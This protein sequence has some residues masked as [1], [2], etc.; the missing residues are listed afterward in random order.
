MG[1]LLFSIL[2]FVAISSLETTRVVVAGSRPT[3]RRDECAKDAG[4]A[5]ALCG[6]ICYTPELFQCVDGNLQQGP[7]EKEPF[8]MTAHSS[9]ISVDGKPVTACGYYFN[10]DDPAK[11]CVWCYNAL[12]VYDCSTYKNQTVLLPSGLM[13]SK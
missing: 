10:I 13:V 8:M 4:L 7:I 5:T 6:S 1:S 2:T 11:T 9:D 3:Y 12:P